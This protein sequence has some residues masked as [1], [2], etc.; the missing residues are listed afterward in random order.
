M[1]M[2]NSNITEGFL[3]Q[4]DSEDFIE[5]DYCHFIGNSTQKPKK[6]DKKQ[7]KNILDSKKYDKN[8]QKMIEILKTIN[9]D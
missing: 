6:Y 9:L 5:F 1:I 2:K 7:L 8:N 4:I 3:S